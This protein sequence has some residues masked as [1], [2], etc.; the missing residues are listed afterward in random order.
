MKSLIT[1]Y[2][3]RTINDLE[4]KE[5][6]KWLTKDKKYIKSFK[7]EVFIYNEQGASDAIFDSKEAFSVFKAR[8]QK[9]ET[10]PI[11]INYFER[12]YKYA[13]AI[14]I[15][16]SSVFM[17][18]HISKD[19]S[20]DVR[21]KVQVVEQG[22]K[23][24]DK[25]VLTLSD[26]TTKGLSS[27]EELSYL[28]VETTETTLEYNE[29][30]VPRGQIFRLVLSDGS[31]VWLNSETK[32]KYPKKFLKGEATR[33]VVLE[34]EA[35][36]EIAHNKEQPFIVNA[37]AINIKVLGTK[38][39]VSSYPN[40]EH[41]NT[42]LVEGSVNVVDSISPDNSILIEPS[43]QASFDRSS[44]SLSSKKVNT[45][46]YLAWMQKKI[47]FE[48]LPFKELLVKIE[49]AYNIVIEN[50]NIGLNNQRFTG[51]F[52][53]EE[54]DVVFKALSTSVYFEYETTSN[55]VTIKN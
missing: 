55:K 39:N 26:G 40:D 37:S 45:D 18:Y 43:F 6:Y 42:T 15:L 13:A 27:E 23:E 46:N 2:L 19:T 44:T 9:E 14:L 29:I 28:A 49:R 31:L 20:V 47:V 34:G 5:L 35:F 16:I 24:T 1:K 41:I 52:D 7:K 21:N 10:K 38:F 17:M 30:N 8:V 22:T 12:Y 25:I 54:V 3:E 36:F 32:L 4:E 51:Q 50:K 33:T 11:K 53:I 48:D